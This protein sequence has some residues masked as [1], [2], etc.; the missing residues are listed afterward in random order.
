MLYLA[1]G[2]FQSKGHRA[3]EEAQAD[4]P[5]GERLRPPDRYRWL[6]MLPPS[7]K[8][9]IGLLVIVSLTA[10]LPVGASGPDY[11]VPRR[12]ALPWPCGQGHRITWGPQEHW[13]HGKATGIAFDFSMDEGTPLF[14]PADGMAYFLRDERPL[15]TNL[16]NYVEVVIE[17][18]WLVRLAHLR[19]PQSGE[20]PVRAGEIIG[21]SGRSGVSTPHLHLELLVKGSTGWARPDVGH[22][23]RFF[24]RPMADFATD[25]I[26]TNDGCPAQLSLDGRLRPTQSLPRPGAPVRLIVPLRNEGLEPTVL[27]T[28]QVCL[29]DPLG[30]QFVAEAEGEW[31]LAGKAA[32]SIVVGVQ[33][34]LAG[35]WR[36]TQVTCQAEGAAF[37]LAADGA[38]AVAPSAIKLVSMTW[39]PTV[40][41][42]DR[43]ALEAWIENRGDQDLV[44]DDVQISGIR[45]DGVPWSASVGREVVASAGDA[46]HLTL[47]SSTV[48]QRVGDWQIGRMGFQQDGHVFFFA[49][50]DETFM[51]VGPELAIDRLAAY[52]SPKTL[53]VFLIMANI[54]TDWAAPDRVEAWGWNP[55]GEHCFTLSNR[56]IAPLASGQSA[57]IQL[58][59]PL[60][61]TGGT[62][63][64]VEVGYWI[65]GQYY[66]MSLPGQPA[67][68]V[69]PS[70]PRDA[71]EEGSSDG[72]RVSQ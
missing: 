49:R 2:R 51:V 46:H 48:P 11:A 52:A 54:G 39:P 47:L 66:P 15:E 31:S 64:L 10:P 43:I 28:V 45:P 34:N 30:G 20:R 42:G 16:G 12:L 36:A 5:L 67:V 38:F 3:V 69:E 27:S 53:D 68:V 23:K 9:A 72:H 1:Q 33:P 55:D 59:T 71:E 63:R 18:D 56:Q 19:D 57:L 41:V 65:Q 44:L 37:R 4:L 14:A 60:E 61:A 40:E 62:W 58:K 29:R 6:Q 17:G 13:A 26:I 70:I 35:T 8:K 24:G 32:R 22:V 7:L 21:H 25:A 50:L